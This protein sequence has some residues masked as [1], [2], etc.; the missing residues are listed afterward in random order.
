MRNATGKSLFLL[1]I[2][3]LVLAACAPAAAPAP[4]GEA[5][6][7]EPIKLTHWIGV[8]TGG[9][10]QAECTIANVVEP[11]N[12]MTEGVTVE[13]V[14]QPNVWE[15]MRTAV[16][17]GGGPDIVTTPGPS[18]VFEMAKSGQAPPAERLCRT[19]GLGGHLRPVG[20]EPS[21]W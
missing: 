5:G 12:E 1:V 21:A 8:G 20:I 16:A 6:A 15:A 7:A 3:S 17:G 10:E 18:F 19:T 4:A 11:Y 2:L 9:S 14:L 13:T